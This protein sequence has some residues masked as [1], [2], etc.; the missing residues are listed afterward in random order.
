LARCAS[1]SGAGEPSSTA[2]RGLPLAEAIHHYVEANGELPST[3]SMETFAK[4]ADIAIE[5]KSKP[6]A[7]H[8]DDAR[9]HR[10]SLGLTTPSENPRRGRPKTPNQ[11]S[12]GRDPRGSEAAR[13]SQPLQRGRL[14]RRPA[15]L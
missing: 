9:A 3:G 11:G 2:D 1:R 13:G 12:G 4:L 7:E 10:S 6:W 15:A 8:L 14:H 5:D